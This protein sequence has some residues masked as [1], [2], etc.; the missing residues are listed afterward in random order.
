MIMIQRTIMFV[1]VSFLSYLSSVGCAKLL[2]IRWFQWAVSHL[3]PFFRNERASDPNF[4][5]MGNAA[6][7]N[8]DGPV[9]VGGDVLLHN[10]TFFKCSCALSW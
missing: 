5:V 8:R 10:I 6:A 7:S 4:A 2:N 9:V 1:C 3:P